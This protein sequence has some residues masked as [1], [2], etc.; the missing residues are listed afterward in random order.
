MLQMDGGVPGFSKDG[1]ARG[2]E[3]T[4]LFLRRRSLLLGLSGLALPNLCRAQASGQAS[5]QGV[6]VFAAASLTEVFGDIGA[7]WEAAGHARLRTSF[8]A[9]ST[10][11]R[12]IEQGAPA[13]LFASADQQWADWLQQRGLLAPGTRRDLLTNNLVL[14]VP[15]ASARTVVIGRDLDLNALL[16]FDGRIA[17]GDPAH[18]PAGIYAQQALT[19][20]GLWTAVEPRLARSDSVRGALLLVERGEAPA[21]IVY[22]TDVAVSPTLAIAGVFPPGS[23]DPITYPFALVK[24]GDTPE[25]R[26][27]LAFLDGP[28]ARAAFERRGFG[29][30]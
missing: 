18:V 22:S 13:E 21:G 7:A 14:V 23:H 26:A 28:Q 27:L 29:R 20:L 11:A 24:G 15:K 6:T 10:L 3:A 12:Q 2:G 19:R 17:V 30:P 8:A 5:P 16:G 4:R 25:A 1:P 9:S